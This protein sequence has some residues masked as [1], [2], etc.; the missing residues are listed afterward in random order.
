MNESL[1]ANVKK[2][3]GLNA[4]TLKMIAILAMTVDHLTWVFL[5]GYGTDFI[6]LSLHIIGRLTAPIMMFFIVEGYFHTRNVKKY[7][8]RMFA[9]AIISHFAYALMFDKSF[10][11]FQNTVFDQTSVMWTLA[12]GLTALAIDKSENPKLKTWHKHILIWFCAIA[13]FCA[14]WSTPAA[15]CILYMGRNRGNFKK[16]MQWLVFFIALYA[17]V[18][19]IFLNPVYGIMQMAVVLSIPLLWKYNGERGKWKGMKWF[20]YIYYP[21]HLAILGL[22]RIYLL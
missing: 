6:T 17:I 20:F 8:F 14:D 22:I 5:P 18:Y 16:Q 9:F 19:A 15:V 1:T 3:S 10:I 13:A 7:I 4:N 12:L 11:P 21:A 2:T